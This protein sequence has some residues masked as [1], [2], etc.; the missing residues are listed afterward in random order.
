MLEIWL[1]V[2]VYDLET[3]YL[4]DTSQCGNVLKGFDGFLSSTKNASN[5]KRPRKFQPEDRLFSLSSV[6]SPALQ[7]QC[8]GNAGL[9]VM[10]R[11][12]ASSSAAEGSELQTIFSLPSPEPSMTRGRPEAAVAG[13]RLKVST[14]PSNGPNKQQQKRGRTGPRDG[15]RIRT[16]TEAAA[17]ETD[18]LDAYLR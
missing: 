11:A 18:E 16:S 5:T 3:S 7:L 17:E 9:A 4:H 6:T 14:T 13:S 12:I 8:C 10:W 2:Q 15:K 1:G